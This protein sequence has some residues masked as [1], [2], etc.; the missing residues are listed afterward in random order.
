MAQECTRT[1]EAPGN[2][3][4][5]LDLVGYVYVGVSP[6]ACEAPNF[7]QIPSLISHVC[8]AFLLRARA[9]LICIPQRNRAEQKAA[10]TSLGY[11]TQLCSRFI[12]LVRSEVEWRVFYDEDISHPDFPTAGAIKT[13]EFLSR[14]RARC[15]CSSC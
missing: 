5:A 12:P 10:I 3:D 7:K 2:G 6:A 4:R 11:Y 1:H 9:D 8:R 14:A 13:C 15:P